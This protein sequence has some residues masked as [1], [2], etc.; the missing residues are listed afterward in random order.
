MCPPFP[1]P[2][3]SPLGTLRLAT[4]A[5]ALCLGVLALHVFLDTYATDGQRPDLAREALGVGAIDAFERR[6]A[7][8]LSAVALV[9]VAGHV[10]AFADMKL[11]GA[12]PVPGV[13]G[14]EVHRLYVHPRF[15]GRGL[16]RAL[17]GWA[18][19]RAHQHG[20][21]QLWLTAWVGNARALGFYPRVGF[22][23]VGLTQHLIE[24]QAWE[25]R[26]FACTL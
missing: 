9:E 20:A 15:H 3:P 7:D 18:R 21:R 8:P 5:D 12:C 13:A 10:V 6:L 1:L 14:P 4:P 24:G 22:R 2:L 16:G 23:D 19:Q 25:N 26:V 17:L 11:E